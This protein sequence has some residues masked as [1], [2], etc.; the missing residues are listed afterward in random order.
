[1]AYSQRKVNTEHPSK[2]I[3]K[4]ITNAKETGLWPRLLLLCGKE[5]FLIDWSKTYVKDQIVNEA[6]AALDCN[7]FS[8]S[9]INAY[10]IIAACETVPLMSERK[11]VIVEDAD[12]FSAQ[13]PKDMNKEELD[14]LTSY[15]PNIPETTLL[16]FTC[17]KPN[18]TRSIYKSIAKHGIVYDFVPL[19][20]AML[21]SWMAKRLKAQNR[22]AKPE[23]MLA[24]AKNC[25]YADP[26]KTYTLNSLEN[27]LKKVFASTDKTVLT[28]DDFM[29]SSSAAAEVNAFKLLDSAFGGKKGDAMT[30]LHNTIDTQTP[31]KEMGA[32][33]SFL[34]LLCSQLEIM[35][36]GKE[37]LEEGQSF[38][39]LAADMGGSEYRL[40]KALEA[41]RNK[42]ATELR[43]SLDNAFQIEK[44]LKSGNIDGRLAL[45]LFIAKL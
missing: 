1:M 18:K 3:V 32:V 17:L 16:M 28:L 35:V 23:D 33:M 31:S 43:T 9:A 25:G 26:D 38:Y 29:E 41:C 30:I 34:G 40:K 39:E 5:D 24:F 11:L 15:L 6:S 10:D 7:I 44:D 8:E 42:N 13:S 45:E 20:D 19:D 14:A 2:T 21:S 12:I 22:S 27:D 4:M 36:E 37:R